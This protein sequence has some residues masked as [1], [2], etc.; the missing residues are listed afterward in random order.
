MVFA[1]HWAKAFVS[2]L[3]KEGQEIQD[4]IETLQI[5]AS[6]ANSLPGELLGRSAA[7]KLTHLIQ[8]GI[9]AMN[10]APA[11]DTTVRFFALLV[12]KKRLHQIDSVISEVKNI[13]DQKRGVM[14]IHV[15]KAFA[16][17]G[18]S[19]KKQYDAI[20]AAL[21]K[22]HPE[23]RVELIERVNP[24]L[25][26]GYRLRMGDRVIDASIRSQLQKLEACLAGDG[27]KLW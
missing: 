2:S 16:R 27:G 6:W 12:K 15:E 21:Q 9:S 7:T 22:H 5:L 1:S 11:I 20:I 13:L 26:G 3:E 18:Q 17:E 14:K 25:I 10:Y 24:A 8:K 23:A 4:G 19:D